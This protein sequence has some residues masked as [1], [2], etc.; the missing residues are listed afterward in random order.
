MG[1]FYCFIVIIVTHWRVWFQFW[2]CALLFSGLLLS[3]VAL[4]F[5]SKLIFNHIPHLGQVIIAHFDSL[6]F[7]FV[8]WC[9]S[10]IEFLQLQFFLLIHFDWYSLFQVLSIILLP[11]YFLL[12]SSFPFL[13][14]HS[15]PNFLLFYNLVQ[16]RMNGWRIVLPFLFWFCW[17]SCSLF[18]FSQVL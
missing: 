5:I 12:Q 3:R 17:R 9:Y 2:C 1:F 7:W 16:S 15:F 8:S 14:L 4:F 18:L 10:R 11:C 13:Q 6:W